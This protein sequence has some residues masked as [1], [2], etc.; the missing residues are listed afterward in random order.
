MMVRQRREA[1]TH[2]DHPELVEGRPVVRQAHHDNLRIDAIILSLPK[3]ALS[4]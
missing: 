3:G 2:H 1:R 4:Q